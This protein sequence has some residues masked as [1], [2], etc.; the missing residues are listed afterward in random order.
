MKYLSRL[1]NIFSKISI[2]TI[3]VFCIPITASGFTYEITTETNFPIDGTYTDMTAEKK[4]IFPDCVKALRASASIFQQRENVLEFGINFESPEGERP[5]QIYLE[6]TDGGYDNVYDKLTTS[7][8]LFDTYDVLKSGEYDLTRPSQ[9]VTGCIVLCVGELAP[10]LPDMDAYWFFSGSG[11]VNCRGIDSTGW[12][13]VGL[14]RN[15][16]GTEVWATRLDFSEERIY[17]DNGEKETVG[18]YSTGSGEVT[19]FTED[20]FILEQGL[21]KYH[22]FTPSDSSMGL[23]YEDETD[24]KAAAI[25]YTATKSDSPPTP[26]P[27]PQASS[28]S[29][30]GGCS[31]GF[32][33]Y[34]LLL[35][36]LLVLPLKK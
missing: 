31:T 7:M 34:I 17:R 29:S 6:R 3:L 11:T 4:A 22:F 13:R 36:P 23:Y 14:A 35:I 32:G 12:W 30:G 18:F 20:G 28:G 10:Q 27:V 8:W 15:D 2:Y 5:V 33:P 16:T 26:T 24:G 19:S 9:A 21:T 25:E 1:W